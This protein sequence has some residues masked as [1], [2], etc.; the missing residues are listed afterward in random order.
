MTSLKMYPNA[1]FSHDLEGNF[2]EVN[3]GFKKSFGVSENDKIP[4]E[5]NIKTLIPDKYKA[6]FDK[7]LAEIVHNGR[8]E[9]F[10]RVI[11]KSG[12]RIFEY[13]NSLI[14]DARGIP[15]GVRGSARDI[16]ERL[17]AERER[18]KLQDQLQRAQ[19]METIGLLAGGVAHDL[20][21]ILSG[22]V[23]YPELLLMEIPED[24]PMR[25][26]LITI[27]KSGEKAASIVQDL[28]TLARKGCTHIG[29][30]ESEP[31]HH[32]ISGQP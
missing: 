16:T 24:S 23:S 3:G 10:I 12:E 27:Q 17:I 1:L 19:K 31:G 18:L 29:G 28:L 4:A 14:R 11:T 9:G 32:G 13:R 8:S 7:Y 26:P 2:I 5:L 6:L 30:S 22:L 25:K 15:K 21:N 20:N